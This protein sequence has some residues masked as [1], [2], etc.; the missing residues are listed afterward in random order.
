MKKFETDSQATY[1]LDELTNEINE[2]YTIEIL[3]SEK[4][5]KLNKDAKISRGMI[6]FS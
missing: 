5:F 2:K 3:N 6:I 1:N 4:T